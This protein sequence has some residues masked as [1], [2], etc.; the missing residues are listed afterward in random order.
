MDSIYD[1]AIG[2]GSAAAFDLGTMGFMQE[3]YAPLRG[4]GGSGSD[5]DNASQTS[6][7]SVHAGRLRKRQGRPGRRKSQVTEARA[8]ERAGFQWKKFS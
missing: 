2:L 3:P 5:A 1:N 4:K 8:S 7:R 6:G